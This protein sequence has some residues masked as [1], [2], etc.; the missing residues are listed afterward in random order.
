[1]VILGTPCVLEPYSKC[2]AQHDDGSMAVEW[3]G[4]R[5]S[6]RGPIDRIV[7]RM[8][9]AYLRTVRNCKEL[10]RNA[11]QCNSGDGC[12][13]WRWTMEMRHLAADS[14]SSDWHGRF[15]AQSDGIPDFATSAVVES[16]GCRV[17]I[18][19]RHRV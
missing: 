4:C 3:H 13:R 18:S 15:G 7:G 19:A 12:L 14:R 8:E 1:M 9:E 2:G 6:G 16:D 11:T 10:A 17:V 5:R